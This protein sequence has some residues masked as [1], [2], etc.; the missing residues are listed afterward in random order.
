MYRISFQTNCYTWIPYGYTGLY[1]GV[2]N[3]LDYALRDLARIGYDGV[4]V[5]CAHILDTRLWKISKT[6]R[7][8]LRKSIE[9]LGIVV[10][11]L[12]AHSWPLP[13]VSFT[14]ADNSSRKLGMDWTKGIIDL[15]AD[16]GTKVVTTHVPSPG[17]Q[18]TELLQGMP[19]GFLRGGRPEFGVHVP[20]TDEERQLM[21]QAVGECAEY[22]K[23]RGV[24]FAIEEYSPVDFWKEFIRDVGSPVLKIN[25]H[26]AQV[27]RE[28]YRTRGLIEEP[29]LPQAVRELGNLIIH[30][31]CMDYRTVSS[32]P[33]L[34][35]PVTRPTVEVIPGTGECDYAAFLKAL[36]EIGYEG[37]L[38]VEC[39]RS[40]I[41]PGI[42]AA[43][44]LQNM[45]RLI[46][47]A[48]G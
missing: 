37:Y 4:E 9:D 46:R 45:K 43:Q 25:L 6:Q 48:I 33:P 36:K 7:Q 22:C 41:P 28:M 32:L 17:K 21:I 11:A 40:D 2:G 29:S 1:P 44:A 42:Q 38:T 10:E 26:L 8:V 15:A 39:H 3:N 12:S 13:G 35:M 30:T 19:H 14:S 5:D 27:W 31:H 47:Q 24:F 20:Y 34:M 18:V 16:F 23:D